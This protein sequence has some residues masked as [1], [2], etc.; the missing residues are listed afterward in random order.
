[1]SHKSELT[2]VIK[3]CLVRLR[4]GFFF[5]VLGVLCYTTLASAVQPLQPPAI[6]APAL[7]VNGEWLVGTQ[8]PTAGVNAFLGVPFAKPPVGELRWREPVGYEGAGGS[9]QV[10]AFAPA[11]MQSMRILDW[12]RGMAERFGAAREIFPDLAVSEDCLYLNVWAPSGARKAN[13]PVMVF[14]HGGSNRS[15]WSFEPNYHGHR[16][17]AE[18]VVVV[19]IAYRLGVFGF[20]SHPGLAKQKVS[21][22]FGLWDQLAALRWI[23]RNIGAFGGDANRV[24]LFGESSGAGNIA[25][26]MLS[27]VARGL[28]HRAILQSGGDFG[29]PLIRTLQAEQARGLQL[30]EVD[31]LES[32]RRIDGRR[33]LQ[34]AEDVFRDHYHAPVLDGVIIRD[35]LQRQLAMGGWPLQQLLIGTNANEYYSADNQRLEPSAIDQAVAKA[36]LLN[37]AEARRA[38]HATPA[39]ADALDRLA[40][41]ES[42]LCPAQSLAA[43]VAKGGRPVWMYQFSR[44]RE[45]D[46]AAALRAYHGAEL[47]YVFGTHD[48]WLPTSKIDEQISRAMMRAW[49]QFARTGSPQIETLPRWPSY[50]SPGRENVLNFDTVTELVDTPESV[51]CGIYRERIASSVSQ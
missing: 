38:L 23:Q 33:L 25:A 39:V 45:G 27:P 34:V 44:V 49:V 48:A 24:T 29:L 51:L 12:Y 16:L 35:S 41:A 36:E 22:N 50:A 32:L 26:L 15:G 2:A 14:V 42:M 13:L 46:A 11:C 8:S 20:F 19:S 37:T 6:A 40:T 18:G 3:V 10:T 43:G 47:P 28:L 5:S 7:Q 9:R 17:A 1:M 31:D 4:R 30:A 21:S